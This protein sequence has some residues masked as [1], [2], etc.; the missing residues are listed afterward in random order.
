MGDDWTDPLAGYVKDQRR[1][2][3]SPTSIRTRSRILGQLS[4]LEPDPWNVTEQAIDDW[5]DDPCKSMGT[6]RCYLVGVSSFYRWAIHAGLTDH[7]PAADIIRPR[8]RRAIPRPIHDDDL[9]LAIAQAKPSVKAMLLLA[10]RQGL[11][12]QE[13]AGLDR[14]DIL[15]R[16]DPP[17]LV[18]RHAKGGRERVLPLHPDVLTALRSAGMNHSGPLF[19]NRHG[20]N[21]SP[22]MVSKRIGTHLRALGITASAHQL[23]HRFATDVYALSRDLRMTQELLGHQSPQ[24][25][26]IYAAWSPREAVGIVRQLGHAT[27]E[28]RQEHPAGL[29]LGVGETA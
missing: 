5:L 6:R 3:L 19:L 4:R 1:R 12:C 23:R 21:L 22:A 17:V 10:A 24:T 20:G 13:I 9:E 18:V 14:D 8:T 2:G 28:E 15:D 7:N 16:A 27:P 26:A 25:T 11:R 29:G